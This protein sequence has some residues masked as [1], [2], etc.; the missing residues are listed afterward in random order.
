MLLHHLVTVYLFAFSY[1]SNQSIGGPVTFLH[2]WAD[3]A[4]SFTRIWSETK[5]ANSIALPS[6]ALMLLVWFYTRLYVFGSLIYSSYSI[7]IY[8]KSPFMKPNFIF[9]LCCLY[10][11]HLYWS[12]MFLKIIYTIIS[13]N[14]VED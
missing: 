10:M 2:N 6:F 11:L 12:Y 7:E 3:V 1:L 13:K 8:T 9:L 14:K 4:I 5:F